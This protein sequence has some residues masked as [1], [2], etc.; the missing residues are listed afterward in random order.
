MEHRFYERRKTKL[1]EGTSLVTFYLLIISAKRT[2]KY[3][4]QYCCHHFHF[5]LLPTP[6][7]HFT[8]IS[9]NLT[10]QAIQVSRN[11]CPIRASN[12]FN[13]TVIHCIMEIEIELFPR[14]TISFFI[15]YIQH[16]SL[17]VGGIP[18]QGVG[19]ILSTWSFVTS[20]SWEV[21]LAHYRKSIHF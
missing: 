14:R 2:Y 11:E 20:P 15:H 21:L 6:Y 4:I 18:P 10:I 9:C 3:E 16:D 19:G 17:P 8:D 13:N 5:S 12:L 1:N 7:F